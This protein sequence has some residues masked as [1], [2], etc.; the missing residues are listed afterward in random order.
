[1]LVSLLG[2]CLFLWLPDYGKTVLA[3]SDPVLTYT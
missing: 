3:N 1:M 2:L